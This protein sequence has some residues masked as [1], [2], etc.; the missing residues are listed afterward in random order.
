[1]FVGSGGALRPPREAVLGMKISICICTCDRP[2]LLKRTLEALHGIRL[3]DSGTTDLEIIVVDNGAN[4]G[5]RSVCEAV[6]KTLPMALHLTEQPRRG[7]SFARNK[8][9]EAALS[10]GAD[11]LAFIDDDDWPEPDWLL[12][13]IETQRSSNADLV[14]GFWHV[15]ANQGLP[16]WIRSTPA[17]QQPVYEA[18]SVFGLPR[19]A[20]TCNVL[21]GVRILER[22][23]SKAEPF[24]AKFAFVGGE[25]KDFFI[26][27]VKDGA[28]FAW[29]QDSVIHKC[30]DAARVTSRGLL[31][32]AFRIGCSTMNL[33]KEHG[34][35]PEVR[36]KRVKSIKKLVK[37]ALAL[38]VSVFR[39][40]RL[41]K[42][43]WRISR[44]LGILYGDIGN[45]FRYYG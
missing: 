22:M 40:D 7:I 18:K 5:A 45:R 16:D 10:R 25:D 12:R 43:L 44:T 31:K 13:L 28:S 21:I 24:S 26:R 9:V 29:T 30:S 20:S 6:S 14:F 3:N 36:K 23:G 32:R 27:A 39:K 4:A 11:F 17:F 15:D 33:L 2:A 34:S 37:S 8:A 1:M 42:H 19:W 35:A 38:P 41:M